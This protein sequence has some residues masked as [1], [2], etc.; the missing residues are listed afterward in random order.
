MSIVDKIHNLSLRI[1]T[2]CGF[3]AVICLAVNILSA[4]IMFVADRYNRKQDTGC[5]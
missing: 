3:G 4:L 1:L 2:L 5:K